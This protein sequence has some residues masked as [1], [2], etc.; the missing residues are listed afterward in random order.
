MSGVDK[1]ITDT[2]K[3][4]LLI[5]LLIVFVAWYFCLI[6]IPMFPNA[7]CPAGI[8]VPGA[9]SG[10]GSSGGG[11]T[12]GCPACICPRADP[13]APGDT[14]PSYYCQ[15]GVKCPVGGYDTGMNLCR[16]PTG[17]FWDGG[18]QMCCP[19]EQLA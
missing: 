10:G 6:I 8:G 7:S 1:I 2:N 11:S 17:Y 4:A 15:Y 5:A 13:T 19:P 9:V 3:R 14:N 12:G 18:I 16:C